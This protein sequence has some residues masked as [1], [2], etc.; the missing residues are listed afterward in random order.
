MA[1]IR[2][3]S[4]T[5]GEKFNIELYENDGK[6]IYIS[7]Y[8]AHAFQTLED[9]TIVCYFMDTSFVPEASIGFNWED[10]FFNISWPFKYNIT[11]SEKD[12]NIPNFNIRTK[13]MKCRH[14]NNELKYEFINSLYIILLHLI[15][16]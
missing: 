13:Y 2:K 16:S 7:P 4:P 1:D 14:C 5:F 3:D 11:I 9:N 6:M 10:P 15:H 8:L 12:K